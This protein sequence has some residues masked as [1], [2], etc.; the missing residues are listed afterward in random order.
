MRVNE[1]NPNAQLFDNDN[2][3]FNDITQG[4]AGTCYILAALG[5]MAEFP[6]LV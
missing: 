3:K 6:D 2:L 1:F 5:A 4:G